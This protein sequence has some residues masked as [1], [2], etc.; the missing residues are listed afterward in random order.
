[1]REICS[2]CHRPLVPVQRATGPELV[3]CWATCP[4]HNQPTDRSPNA[5]VPQGPDAE[6]HDRPQPSHQAVLED[7]QAAVV[8]ASGGEGTEAITDEHVRF[9]GGDRS[10]DRAVTASPLGP[11]TPQH[12]GEKRADCGVRRLVAVQKTNGSTRLFGQGHDADT[13]NLA[14]RESAD[15]EHPVFWSGDASDTSSVDGARLVDTDPL[16]KA[17]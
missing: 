16:S 6:R 5:Q 3:C 17:A 11:K 2:T 13:S 9:S 15:T 14:A 8:S 1:M 7:G 10:S 4:G 12:R